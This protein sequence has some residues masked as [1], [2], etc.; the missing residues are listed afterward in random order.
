MKGKKIL[1]GTVVG[2]LVLAVAVQVLRFGYTQFM[3]SSYPRPEEYQA[4]VTQASADTGVSEALIYAVIR[5]ESGFRPQVES[6]AGAIGLMQITP[7]TFDWI[8]FMTGWDEPL[9]SEDL[10]DPAVNIKYGTQLLSILLTEF[11]TQDEALAAY[12]AGR[13]R[14]NQWLKDPEYSE[15]G[16]TLSYIPIE[17]TRNYVKKVE[18]ARQTYQRLYYDTASSRK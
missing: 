10:N 5:T 6:H 14:V 15:D 17:E 1:L 12:N 11:E 16:E 4:L 9:T 2:I 3:H 8:R 13:S 18:D 7:A